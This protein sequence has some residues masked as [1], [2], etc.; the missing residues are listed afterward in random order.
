[1]RAEV[2]AYGKINLSIDVLGRLDNGYH[3]VCMV[4]QLI[5]LHD[6]LCFEDMVPGKE[7][8]PRYGKGHDKAIKIEMKGPALDSRGEG[9]KHSCGG[10]ELLSAADR[11][12]IVWKAWELL[13][14][15]FPHK[16]RSLQVTI[17]KNIPVAAGLAGGSADGAAALLALNKMW[18]LGLSLEEL[19]KLGAE[20]GADV[21][22]SLAG[23]AKLNK[24]Y[25]FSRDGSAC[26]CA[27]AEGTGTVLTPLPSWES[28]VVL[29]RPPV[30]V[31]T[32]RVYAGIDSVDIPRRPRT[33]ELIAGIR[34]KNFEKISENMVNVLENYSL[35]VYHNVVYTKNNMEAIIGDRG[36]VLMSGSGPTV[37]GLSRDRAVCEKACEEMSKI[38]RETFLS[39]TV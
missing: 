2:D 36:K 24:E 27:L 20:L 32:A 17:E 19:K 26:T 25:G 14:K 10:E 3:E 4:M 6:H 35:K 39:R 18:S 29:S 12:N 31:S 33:D 11:D 38:N 9:E 16:A 1:M 30:H 13:E 22:F 7:G 15:R 21:P 34:E 23:Q 28:P 5:S 37:Y 8:G